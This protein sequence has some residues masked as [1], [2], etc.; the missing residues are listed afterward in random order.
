MPQRLFPIYLSKLPS[1]MPPLQWQ[2]GCLNP[3]VLDSLE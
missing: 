3:E 2:Q 1:N